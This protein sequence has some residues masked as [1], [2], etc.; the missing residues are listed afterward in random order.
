MLL[1]NRSAN[2]PY[3]HYCLVIILLNKY[4]EIL[5]ILTKIFNMRLF[6]NNNQFYNIFFRRIS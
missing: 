3:L 4:F 6:K 5:N 2:L 1:H